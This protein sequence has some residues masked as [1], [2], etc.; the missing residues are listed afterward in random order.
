MDGVGRSS[1][2]M[3]WMTTNESLC[4]K[5]TESL[6]ETDPITQRLAPGVIVE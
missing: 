3:G 2:R 6:L 4:L 1:I 5:T